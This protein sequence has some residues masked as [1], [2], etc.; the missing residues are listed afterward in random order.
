MNSPELERFL[1]TLYID[2][3]AR[4]KFLAAPRE[5]AARAGLSVEQCR[6]LEK[7]DRIGLEMAALSFS[8]K[9]AVKGGCGGVGK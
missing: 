2:S 6:A 5:E 9:R 8:R 1:A 4:A 3:K 7:I